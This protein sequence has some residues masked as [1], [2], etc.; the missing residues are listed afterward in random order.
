MSVGGVS[1]VYGQQVSM[2]WDNEFEDNGNIETESQDNTQSW[3]QTLDRGRVSVMSAS[4]STNTSRRSSMELE[5]SRG[6]SLMSAMCL[7]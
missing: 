2:E 5:L 1:K 3:L 7:D 6:E 4:S